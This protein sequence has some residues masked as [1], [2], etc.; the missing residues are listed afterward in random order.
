MCAPAI[1]KLPHKDVMPSLL[2]TLLN[3]GRPLSSQPSTAIQHQFSLESVPDSNWWDEERQEDTERWTH[4][5]WHA[6]SEDE[7]QEIAPRYDK[8]FFPEGE[9]RVPSP[10]SSWRL[11]ANT[12]L[13]PAQK[14]EFE[15]AVT[16]HAL[17]SFRQC[18]SQGEELLVLDWQHTCYRLNV[19][20]GIRNAYRD[21]WAKP[22]LTSGDDVAY[23][24]EDFQFGLFSLRDR[25]FHVF[26][27]AFLE[28]FCHEFPKIAVL[29]R[30]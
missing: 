23:L 29:D 12:Q 25:T 9:L 16:M 27:K 14:E 21:E 2:N 10:S 24:S 18:V 5:G 26:G 1:Y 11:N 3:A 7:I 22:I 15:T 17:G 19:Y 8:R 28:V 20:Q 6:L 4:F 30:I 13:L